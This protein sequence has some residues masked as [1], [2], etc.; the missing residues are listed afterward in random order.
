MLVMGRFG[1]VPGFLKPPQARRWGA[2]TG[3][4]LC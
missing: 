2:L 4:S 1:A 3:I